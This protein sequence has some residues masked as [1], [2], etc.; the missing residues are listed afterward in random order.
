MKFQD[1]SYCEHLREDGRSI[2]CATGYSLFRNN[3]M[4]TCLSETCHL[5]KKNTRKMI[6]EKLERLDKK[7]SVVI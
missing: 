2:F 5:Y 3:G 1:C 7:N 4:P 6:M